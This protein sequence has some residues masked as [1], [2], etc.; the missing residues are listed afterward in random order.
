M[1]ISKY[2]A[3]EAINI[4]GWSYIAIVTNTIAS[5]STIT[6]SL[7]RL[8]FCLLLYKNIQKNLK[9]VQQRFSFNEPEI[10]ENSFPNKFVFSHILL[11]K[12][13]CILFSKQLLKCL[14]IFFNTFCYYFNVKIEKSSAIYKHFYG[15]SY[16]FVCRPTADN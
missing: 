11:L 15:I 1:C 6:K 14:Q 2:F 8:T 5:M 12:G 7:N 4:C 13:V 3:T 16:I 10:F 9:P